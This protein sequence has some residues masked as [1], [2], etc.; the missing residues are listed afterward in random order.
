VLVCAEE[1]HL[2]RNLL[3]TVYKG[4]CESEEFQHISDNSGCVGSA[5]LQMMARMMEHNSCAGSQQVH[6]D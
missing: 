6:I 3:P 4:Q 2:C 5:V 1:G